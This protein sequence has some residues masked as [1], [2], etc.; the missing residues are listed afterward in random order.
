MWPICGG[1][2]WPKHLSGSSGRETLPNY[3]VSAQW[4]LGLSSMFWMIR[5]RKPRSTA[6]SSSLNPA[7]VCSSDLCNAS[8][9]AALV[10][11]PASVRYTRETRSSLGS[12]LRS[13]NPVFSI[14]LIITV[15]VAELRWS[16]LARSEWVIPSCSHSARS[17][18]GWPRWS[19]R[20]STEPCT[21][22][23]SRWQNRAIKCPMRS[24]DDSRDIVPRSLRWL[25]IRRLSISRLVFRRL[26]YIPKHLVC[27]APLRYLLPTSRF[28]SLTTD[29]SLIFRALFEIGST[30]LDRGLGVE[31]CQTSN[32]VLFCEL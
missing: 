20:P 18:D 29:L 27:Q 3:Q 5:R 9:T 30:A 16:L 28:G 22:R 14:R 25:I 32:T 6:I 2:R 31:R 17:T 1:R 4:E 19:P 8:S 11:R 10:S 23:W 21:R 15:I 13:T 7:N 24:G 26:Y 12:D